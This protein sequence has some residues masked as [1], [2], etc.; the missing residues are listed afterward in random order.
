MGKFD[1][2]DEHFEGLTSGKLLAALYDENSCP[3]KVLGILVL[4]QREEFTDYVDAVDY[5]KGTSRRDEFL[6]WMDTA[7]PYASG[8]IRE[9]TGER[10]QDL[11]ELESIFR[12]PQFWASNFEEQ[13]ERLGKYV[14]KDIDIAFLRIR[15]MTAEGELEDILRYA[16]FNRHHSSRKLFDYL[17]DN[18]EYSDTENL[19]T[20]GFFTKEEV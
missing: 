5:I 7:Y 10:F 8:K 18:F 19:K 15:D 11:V 16:T 17:L 4:E 1:F 20:V 13:K 2:K 14:G 9:L 6:N 12:L 3:N